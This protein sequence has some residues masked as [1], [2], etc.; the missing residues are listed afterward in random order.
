MESEVALITICSK[1]Q[2][3][4][5][6][7]MKRK[8]HQVRRRK[9][10]KKRTL[11][12]SHRGRGRCVR[13]VHLQRHAILLFTSREIM[14]FLTQLLLSQPLPMPESTP[15]TSEVDMDNPEE[16]TGDQGSEYE[17]DNAVPETPSPSQ[18]KKTTGG[19]KRPHQSSI[20]STSSISMPATPMKR[21]R[22]MGE[23]PAPPA[24]STRQSSRRIQQASTAE[25]RARSRKPDD[26]DG[27][28]ANTKGLK[29]LG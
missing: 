21:G 11:C 19:G 17:G 16:N 6:K 7:I 27:L 1:S 29:K 5:R 2:Q 28:V 18:V 24:I 15:E 22:I 20:T 10:G 14:P 4:R 26:D 8:S 12:L 25:G 13:R 23:P 3:V 9:K